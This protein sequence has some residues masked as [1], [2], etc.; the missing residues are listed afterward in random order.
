[1]IGRGEIFNMNTMKYV[2][3]TN[4]RFILVPSA[5]AHTSMLSDSDIDRVVSAGEVEFYYDGKNEFNEQRICCICRGESTTLKV[6][7]RFEED[8]RLINLAMGI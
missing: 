5:M 7:S 3:F 1:M 4:D 8:E 6:K 2:M